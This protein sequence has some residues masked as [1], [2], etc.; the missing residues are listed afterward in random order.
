[1]NTTPENRK[2][3]K[4]LLGVPSVKSSNKEFK[5]NY[6]ESNKDMESI[7]VAEDESEKN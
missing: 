3:I 4:N 6:K 2:I 5:K 1:M 7:V